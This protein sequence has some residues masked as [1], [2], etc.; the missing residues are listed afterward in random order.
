MCIRDRPSHGVKKSAFRVLSSFR[1]AGRDRPGH[2]A[3]SEQLFA[4]FVRPTSWCC[5]STG[6]G[7]RRWT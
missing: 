3:A 4:P 1:G 7:L 5:L 2:A 6:C